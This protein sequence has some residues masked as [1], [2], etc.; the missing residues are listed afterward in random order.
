MGSVTFMAES[1]T[2]KLVVETESLDS[3]FVR[4][5]LKH[6]GGEQILV[7]FQCG[8]CTSSCPL[9]LISPE[10]N[11]RRIVK[12]AVLGMKDLVL[13]SDFIWFCA[14]CNAC[15]ERCPQG[16]N[17]SEVM[18]AIK[19]IAVEEGI[20]PPAVKKIVENIEEHGRLYPI[21]DFTQEEREMLDL[22]EIEPDVEVFKI[23][24]KKLLGEKT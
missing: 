18:K 20:A 5:I 23:N 11:P 6:P 15:T 24:K 9:R 21:E 10:Y 1:E 3:S 13:S 8:V 19:N 4:K 7:C 12:E 17:P 2:E 14:D 22:P 16:V